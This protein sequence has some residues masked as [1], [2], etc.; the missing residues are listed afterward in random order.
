MTV[1]N[2][3][4]YQGHPDWECPHDE[5]VSRDGDL[6]IWRCNL[7]DKEAPWSIAERQGKRPDPD[8]YY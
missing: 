1:T 5:G 8:G 6:L 7:C 4:Y 2:D 3:P